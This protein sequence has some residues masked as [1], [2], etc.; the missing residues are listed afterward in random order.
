MACQVFFYPL[1]SKSSFAPEIQSEPPDQKST[2]RQKIG[3]AGSSKA[4]LPEG[5][6][7]TCPK[8][9]DPTQKEKPEN[10]GKNKEEDR[11][12]KATL[13]QLSETGNE[14][15]REGGNHIACGSLSV[16]HGCRITRGHSAVQLGIDGMPIKRHSTFQSLVFRLFLLPCRFSSHRLISIWPSIMYRS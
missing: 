6:V 13:D 2:K 15:A 16:V 4:R 3:A 7:K 1:Q 14:K 12:E 9:D 8:V 11:R 5:S 10:T